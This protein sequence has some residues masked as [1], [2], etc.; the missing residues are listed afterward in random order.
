MLSAYLLLSEYVSS[1]FAA[2]AHYHF[3]MNLSDLTQ[4]LGELHENN[5]T[6]WFA[7]QRERYTS[8]RGQFE[9]LVEGV[10]AKVA[11]FDTQIANQTPNSLIFRLN[12]DVRFSKDKSPYKTY[13]G[14][15]LAPLGRR[16]SGA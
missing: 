12:R 11:T 13:F 16:N 5:T 8:L 1:L 10:I 14:A 15:G 6:T 7:S 3:P 4:F 9:T 2:R